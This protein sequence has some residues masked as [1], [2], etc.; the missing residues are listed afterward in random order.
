MLY[1]AIHCDERSVTLDLYEKIIKNVVDNLCY[2][3]HQQCKMSGQNRLY[4][5]DVVRTVHHWGINEQLS[6]QFDE[7]VKTTE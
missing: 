7:F 4:K 6:K 5:R 2:K 1:P 3:L